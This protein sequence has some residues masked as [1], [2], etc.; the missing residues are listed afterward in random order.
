MQ[1][2]FSHFG[3][4]LKQADGSLN[5]SALGDIIFNDDTAKKWLENK[6]H[7]YV[8]DRFNEESAKIKQSSVVFAI[9][10]LFEAV[11]SFRMMTV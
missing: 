2:I 10:L 4:H 6:I 1:D 7:P 11:R 8:R 9:P 3:N 5:R